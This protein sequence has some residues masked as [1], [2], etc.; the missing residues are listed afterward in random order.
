MATSDF[1]KET[2]MDFRGLSANPRGKARRRKMFGETLLRV[3][4]GVL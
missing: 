2:S 4:D 1:G 3:E